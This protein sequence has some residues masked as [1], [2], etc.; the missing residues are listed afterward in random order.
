MGAGLCDAYYSVA[1]HGHS[2]LRYACGRACD[3]RHK[4]AHE[5][6]RELLL[7]VVHSVVQANEALHSIPA[8]AD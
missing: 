1:A 2:Q 7:E 8:A 6:V 4:C 3:S 5:V